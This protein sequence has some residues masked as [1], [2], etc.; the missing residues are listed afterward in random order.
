MKFGFIV[1]I[2]V[3]VF[4]WMSWLLLSCFS[5]RVIRLFVLV[6]GILVFMSYFFFII[7]DLIIIL[8]CFIIW[9]ML[10]W[11]ILRRKVEFCLFEMVRLFN[12]LW[13]WVCWLS[14]IWMR[15]LILLWRIESNFFFF[16]CCIVCCIICWVW[17]KS[18]WG[19]WSGES[20][21]MWFRNL[22]I[23][24]VVFLIY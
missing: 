3:L 7:K 22:I 19:V 20:M 5:W 4:I 11:F 2:F 17:V 8:V 24:L 21:V 15:W 9:M 1:W 12:V 23:M 16:I 18:L 6:N 13:I 10:K 14:N